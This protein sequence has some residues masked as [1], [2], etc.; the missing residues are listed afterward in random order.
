MEPYLLDPEN[1]IIIVYLLLAPLPLLV[2]AIA[3]RLKKND[4]V[5]NGWVLEGFPTNKAQADALLQIDIVPN[6]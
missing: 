2:E 4:C 3:L 5:N 6:R 1:G